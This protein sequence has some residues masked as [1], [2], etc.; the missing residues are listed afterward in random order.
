M[1]AMRDI[2]MG[3]VMITEKPLL[4]FRAGHGLTEAL[5]KMT[6][7]GKRKLMTLYDRDHETE[8]TVLGILLTNCVAGRSATS[9]LYYTI[10]RYQS[11]I[12]TSSIKKF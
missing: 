7:Q 2:R 9:V 3:E 11:F 6:D 10:S 8:G 5:T 12:L 4:L 1:V